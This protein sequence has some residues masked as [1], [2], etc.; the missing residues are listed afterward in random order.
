MCLI[1]QASDAKTVA[2]EVPSE[3]ALHSLAALVA[4][5][6]PQS[7]FVTLSGDLGAGKTTFVK[8]VAA[9]VGVHPSLVVSPTFGL[10]HLH[11]VCADPLHATRPLRIVHADFY[12]LAGSTDLVEIGWGDAIG[13]PGWVF[14]E[15]ANRIADVLPPD[16]L[17][18]SIEVPSET[19]RIFTFTSHG[20]GCHGVISAIHRVNTL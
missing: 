20:H 18:V 11:A 10:I 12:R 17:E 19:S 15:W 2:T 13:E 6:L 5:V 16:R 8:A 1:P 9:A 4:S 3:T 14:V 7:A